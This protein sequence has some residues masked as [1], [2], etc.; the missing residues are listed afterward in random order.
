MHDAFIR[1]VSNASTFRKISLTK[2]WAGDGKAKGIDG[3]AA[4]AGDRYSFQGGKCPIRVYL[5]IHSFFLLVIIQMSKAR[6][7]S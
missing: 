3:G 7:R 4:E 5:Y 6:N 2:V 1:S